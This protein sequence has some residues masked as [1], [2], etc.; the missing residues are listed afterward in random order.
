M[1]SGLGSIGILSSLAAGN[2][3]NPL[4]HQELARKIAQTAGELGTNL[5]EIVWALKPGTPTLEAL[6]YHLAERGGRLFPGSGVEF[7]TQFPV[8][9]PSVELSLAVRRNVLLIASE[10]MHNAA[11]HAQANKIVLG[12][13]PSVGRRWRLW[14]DDDGRGLSNGKSNENGSGMGLANIR[15][16]A[17]EIGALLSIEPKTGKGT[18][19]SLIFN[20]RADS[21]RT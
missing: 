15:R 16:R 6:A 17:A 4:E 13:E 3:M 18:S 1:G 14:L 8:I 9:W 2:N 19:L 10:A 12:L 21:L 5:T 7:T 20:P 11:R